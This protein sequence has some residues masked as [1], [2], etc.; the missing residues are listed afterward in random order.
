M[1]DPSPKTRFDLEARLCELLAGALREQIDLAD[2]VNDVPVRRIDPSVVAR[3]DG[4][5]DAARH[6]LRRLLAGKTFGA[7]D[8]WLAQLAAN[9]PESNDDQS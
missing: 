6:L 9:L 1:N 4:R 5:I 2:Y 3:L 8:V 7:D